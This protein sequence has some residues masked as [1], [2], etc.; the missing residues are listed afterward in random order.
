VGEPILSRPVGR[1]RSAAPEPQE[2]E[3]LYSRTHAAESG[4]HRS[5]SRV[6]RK[7]LRLAPPLARGLIWLAGVSA[8]PATR[9][10]AA[11]PR[12]DLIPAAGGMQ[13]RGTCCP[14]SVCEFPVQ[15]P[16][17]L[18]SSFVERCLALGGLPRMPRVATNAA[19]ASMPS[20]IAARA[21]T[22]AAW[23]G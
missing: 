6:E 3:T 11:A 4:E 22:L 14:V 5:D 15:A 7:P 8:R 23:S 10:L 1:R 12:T 20:H 13:W 19:L 21:H 17:K 9:R 2:T 16:E 18:V